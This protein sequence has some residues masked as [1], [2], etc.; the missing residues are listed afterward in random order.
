MLQISRYSIIEYY[1]NILTIFQTICSILVEANDK[2][3][4]WC[5]EGEAFNSSLDVGWGKTQSIQC[6]AEKKIHIWFVSSSY[7]SRLRLWS[8]YIHNVFNL[9][10]RASRIILLIAITH[11]WVGGKSSPNK[12]DW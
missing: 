12:N 9:N 3:Y 7:H 6:R 1:P 11:V 10:L 8:E 5:L 2:K 4:L